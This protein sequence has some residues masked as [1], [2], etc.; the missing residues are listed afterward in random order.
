MERIHYAGGDVLTGSVIAQTLLRYAGLL[1]ESDMSMS[2]D[3]PVRLDDGSVGQATLL[4]GPA[5]QVMS[6]PEE[7]PFEELIDDAT[8]QKLQDAARGLGPVKVQPYDS[9]PADD[10][11]LDESPFSNAE[12]DRKAAEER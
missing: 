2:V 7:S 11:E 10:E 8:V 12:W 4:V 3:I 1:A 9:I 6:E 5:S